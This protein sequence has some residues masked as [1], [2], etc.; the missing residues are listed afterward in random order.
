MTKRTVQRVRLRPVQPIDMLGRGTITEY[1]EIRGR[2]KA[3][4]CQR[5]VLGCVPKDH[6]IPFL[7][8]EPVATVFPSGAKAIEVKSAV[9]PSRMAMH[10]PS[11]GKTNGKH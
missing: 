5:V 1:N 6:I 11:K 7:S 10:F 3:K 2:R 9:C 8:S 4:I